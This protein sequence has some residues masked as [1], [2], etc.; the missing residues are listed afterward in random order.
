[1]EGEATG[2]RLDYHHMLQEGP[3]R[4]ARNTGSVLSGGEP[5]F[6]G[7]LYHVEG[8]NVLPVHPFRVFAAKGGFRRS[9]VGVVS[10]I[11]LSRLFVL[12]FFWA[13]TIIFTI[14]FRRYRLFP[15]E[16]FFDHRV[17]CLSFHRLSL[18]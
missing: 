3:C 14:F 9:N 1:M 2:D 5:T 4:F 11:R 6:R 17:L 13:G 12:H 18:F 7:H 8:A 15:R 16:Y 10:S